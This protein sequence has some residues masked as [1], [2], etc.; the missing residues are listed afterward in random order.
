M[1]ASECRN[2]GASLHVT[3]A[4]LGAQPLSNSYV[5]R[6]RA[7]APEPFY[8]LHAFVC[9][10]CFLV[11][12]EAFESPENIFGDY[13]YFSSYSDTWLAHS[14]ALAR[15]AAI[16]LGLGP[17]SLVIEAASNDGYL[18]QYFERRGIPVLGIEPAHNVAAAARE[19]GIPTVSVFLGRETAVEIVREHNQ[20][21]LV[22]ANNVIAHVPDLHDFVEGLSVLLAPGKAL[23]I[24]FPHLMQLIEQVQFDTIYHE[25]FSYFSLHSMELVLRAHGLEVYD[26]DEIPTHGG[27][28]R[29]WASNV[30][31]AASKRL[32]VLRDKEKR[33]GITDLATYASFAEKVKQRKR[34]LL[35]FL[36]DSAE[37]G[38]EIAGYGAPAKG[39][40]LLN[41]CGVRE[42][43]LAY[44]VD[45]N[46][47]K[48]NTLLPGSRIP[49]YAPERYRETRPDYILIL[50]W[51]I[52]DEIVAQTSYVRDWGAKY[53]VAIPHLEVF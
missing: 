31:I 30:P 16:N 11:Q 20:A 47:V 34:D 26:V 21:D 6:E 4:D 36:M 5:A 41:Y 38:L 25:H 43:L 32:Q 15:D 28:L 14:E 45:R 22:I 13:A 40:T 19:R 17:E 12:L 33:F 9:E 39:N 53:V 29:V 8:P 27:S 52:R 7:K 24:E 48:Q 10:R 35:R 37:K 23:S 46:P 49:V 2:C 44:T 42:D 50:P 18:L 1:G 3:F 51:N